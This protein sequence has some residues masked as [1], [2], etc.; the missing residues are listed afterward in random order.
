MNKRAC[1]LSLSAFLLAAA[2]T[3]KSDS[4]WHTVQF[5]PVERNVKLEVLD[6]GGSGRPLV[7]LAGLGNTAHVFDQFAPRLTGFGHVYGITRRGFAPSSVPTPFTAATYS[8]DRLGD[9]VLA[10]IDHLRLNRPVLIGHS[11]AGEELSSIGSRHPEK[12]AG[13]VYLDAAY[14]YAFYNPSRGDLNLDLLDLEKKLQLMHLGKG[15]ND[16]RPVIHELL[17]T[18][19]PRFEGDLRDE[20]AFLTALPPKMLSGSS[21]SMKPAAQA[22]IAGEQKYTEIKAPALAI[23]AVPHD[24]GPGNDPAAQAA[25]DAID[26]AAVGAQAAAFE[27]G[28]PSARVVRLRHAEHFV[29]RSNEADVLR[30]IHNFV[31]SLQ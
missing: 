29:F 2:C 4:S 1:A 24:I 10:V 14:G 28:V 6:W 5:V 11:I 16:T 23:F 18:L 25:F 7:L 17:A 15:P 3:H 22:I 21:T 13:L 19:L 8:A 31:S 26:G 30:E 27:K 12:V 20:Q 9:D